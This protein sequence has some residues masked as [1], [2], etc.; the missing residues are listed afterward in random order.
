MANDISEVNH[1]RPSHVGAVRDASTELDEKKSAQVDVLDIEADT[2]TPAGDDADDLK[3][4]IHSAD[5]NELT[6]VEA[7]QWN[8]EGDQSPCMLLMPITESDQH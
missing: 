4:N 1:D 3:S 2:N 6:P 7:F 8:V 5:E